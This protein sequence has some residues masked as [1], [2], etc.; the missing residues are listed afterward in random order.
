[1]TTRTLLFVFASLLCLN[2]T[3]GCRTTRNPV[4]GALSPAFHAQVETFRHIERLVEHTGAFRED[5]GR[6]PESMDEFRQYSR[7]G[8][9]INWEL[10]DQVFFRSFDGNSLDI[11]F[12]FA[13]FQLD[14]DIVDGWTVNVERAFGVV[15]VPGS[16][17]EV[18]S[19]GRLRI[20]MPAIEGRATKGRSL[21]IWETNI[22][23]HPEY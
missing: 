17:S 8:R 21:V 23:V 7:S 12:R 3:S 11:E 10:Y 20:E 13:P 15:V 19:H 18:G 5:H 1:M 16:D 9:S 2:L 14:P 6:W 4:G 22:E